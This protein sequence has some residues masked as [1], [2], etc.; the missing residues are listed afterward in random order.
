MEQI[1]RLYSVN[2]A[3]GRYVF[4]RLVEGWVS[5]RTKL[6]MHEHTKNVICVFISPSS[7]P[8]AFCPNDTSVVLMNH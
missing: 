3:P 1:L 5:V 2:C 8:H 6:R 7:V 4:W